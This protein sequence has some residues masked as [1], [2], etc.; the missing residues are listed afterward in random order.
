M[1]LTDEIERDSAIGLLEDTANF[2][3]GM[4][5]DPAIPQHAKEAI[6]SR[7]SKLDAFT[8]DAYDRELEKE[9]T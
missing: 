7:L 8:G 5:L 2:L 1:K 6:D 4:R 9:E 3:R